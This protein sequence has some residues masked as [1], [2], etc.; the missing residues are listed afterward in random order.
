[1]N[2]NVAVTVIRRR[3]RRRRREAVTVRLTN[4]LTSQ[5]TASFE[6]IEASDRSLAP[7]LLFCLGRLLYFYD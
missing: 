6:S 3:L 5:L 7:I 4:K 1:M 2:L